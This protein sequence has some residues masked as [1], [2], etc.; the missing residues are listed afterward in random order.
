VQIGCGLSVEP[1]DV[2]GWRDALAR[3][4]G[5]PAL[6]AKMGRRGR[7]F[8]E[9]GYNAEAFGTAVVDAVRTAAERMRARRAG[10]SEP[11]QWSSA[12]P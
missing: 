1:Y 8:A 3:L 9:A 7:E 2:A 10:L 6:R 12:G 11:K 5:D 4:A